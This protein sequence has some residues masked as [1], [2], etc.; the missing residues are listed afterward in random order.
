LLKAVSDYGEVILEFV[1]ARRGV[2]RPSLGSVKI[3]PS[4]NSRSLAA[5]SG[6]APRS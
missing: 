6:A 5:S 1:W 3:Q 4:T 2:G